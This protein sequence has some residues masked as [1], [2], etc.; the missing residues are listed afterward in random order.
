MMPPTKRLSPSD[1]TFCEA[2]H[3]L[4]FKYARQL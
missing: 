4:T 1:L 3:I 2:N